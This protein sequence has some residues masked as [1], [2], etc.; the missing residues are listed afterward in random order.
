MRNTGTQTEDSLTANCTIRKLPGNATVYNHTDTIG[1]LGSLEQTWAQFT[2]DFVPD[3][4]KTYK[5]TITSGMPHDG[6]TTNNT[7]TAGLYGFT[8]PQELK[9]DDGIA[10]NGR[11]WNGDFSG[12]GNEFQPP[13][14]VLLTSASFN[15][16]ASGLTGDAIVWVLQDNPSG[17]P[18]LN[19]ILFSD[20]V[21]V[22]SG[23]TGW[24]TIS[25]V[26]QNLN[27]QANQ[28]FYVVGIHVTQST[29]EFG[30]DQ[31]PTNPLSQ[32]G[33]EFTGGLAPDR[34]R[35]S[36]NIMIKVNASA[37]S[38]GIEEEIMPKS[39]TLSQNYPNPFN[40]QT[41]IR[42]SLSKASDVVINIYS[43]TGQMVERIK[44]SYPAGDNVI[45]WNASDKASGVYFYRMNVGKNVDIK[46]MILV[47]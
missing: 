5:V 36:V 17:Q 47:K 4:I 13:V 1:T 27:F 24:K 28:K 43:I 39:F 32:R 19:N 26:G 31:T 8:L 45:T 18:D 22:D 35:D 3:S 34:N 30:M 23:F 42:F 14:P 9:Y 7:K 10:D 46:K 25:L 38:A 29:F 15:V 33:W 44:G 2:P 11:A 21:S 20:T 16:N 41:N 40:A 37:G 12:F 6:N